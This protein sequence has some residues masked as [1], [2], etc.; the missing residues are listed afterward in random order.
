MPG[1]LNRATATVEPEPR[2]KSPGDVVSPRDKRFSRPGHCFS[3]PGRRL[4]A[5]KKI[6]ES[7]QIA[8]TLGHLLRERSAPENDEQPCG[9]VEH[10]PGLGVDPDAAVTSRGCKSS[11]D[12]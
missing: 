11:G 2:Q 3:R 8:G 12:G 7:S 9:Q 5:G 1:G 4:C 6:P 10:P